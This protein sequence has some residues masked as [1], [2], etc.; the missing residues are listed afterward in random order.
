MKRHLTRS[1]AAKRSIKLPVVWAFAL[2]CGTGGTLALAQEQLLLE[3]IFDAEFY[4]T[5]A[6]SFGLARNDGKLSSLGRLQIWSAFQINP[7]L[8][9]YALGLIEADDASGEA[10]SDSDLRQFAL[11]YS[12]NAS[13]F[14]MIEAGKLL[15]PIA[16]AS[17]RRF[18]SQNPLIGEPN[19]LY[20]DYPLGIQ[21][22]GS[23]GWFDYRAAL[24]DLPAVEPAYLP[25]DPGS[26]LRPDVGA[27]ITPVPGLR[28]GVAYTKGP[29]LAR[30]LKPYL[31]SGSGWKDFHQELL[32]LE[33][34]FSYR[35]LEFNGELLFSEYEIPFRSKPSKV[36]GYFLELKY[37][38]TPRLYGAV[39]F[40]RNEYPFI[41]RPGGLNWISREVTA[42]DVEVG[43][44]YRFTAD[45]QIKL[46]YRSDHRSLDYAPEGFVH[47]GHSLALQLSHHFDLGSWLERQR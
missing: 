10:E 1:R 32:G 13:P 27:G 29:F 24:V 4:K 18:S 19:F 6:H 20:A 45:T 35:Y 11:R 26:A 43:L 3:G 38:W 22:A 41:R 44:G 2:F 40:E 46:T 37:T 30:K 7:D 21:V 17:E 12:S 33:F 9:V 42:H 25:A 14:Y 47:T 23:S 36:T 31:P 28:F 5:D 39:R 34:Q 16:V 15:P 8:Q